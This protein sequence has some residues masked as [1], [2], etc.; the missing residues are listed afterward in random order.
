MDTATELRAARERR[1]LSLQQ[2]SRVTRISLRMLQAI[3]ANDERQLPAPVFT[4][5]FIRSY[6][7][8]VGLRPDDTAARYLAQFVPPPA[9]IPPPASDTVPRGGCANINAILAAALGIAVVVLVGILGLSIVRQAA[10]RVTHRVQA[11]GAA[12][13][14][15][16]TAPE[17]REIPVGTI[18]SGV[19]HAPASNDAPLE[20]VIAPSGPCWVRATADGQVA[21]ATLLDAGDRRTVNAAR[22]LTLRVGDPATFAFTLNG[23]PGR[24]VG[25]PA[26]P[27]TLQI[28]AGRIG[29]LV[30]W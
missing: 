4:R 25:R 7:R 1:G 28:D 13:D 5:S 29:E 3:E 12:L 27:V 14:R 30:N 15:S 9:A 26:Q 22:E 8:E 6:A 10:R 23:R 11:P 2:M 17:P 24:S 16:A 19:A 20:I 21:F 18:G